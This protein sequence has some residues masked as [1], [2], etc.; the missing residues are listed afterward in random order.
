MK[1]RTIKVIA[2]YDMSDFPIDRITPKEYVEKM[3]K[4]DMV[5]QFGWDEGYLGVKVEVIDE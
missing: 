4:K 1:K 3:V 5:D 2:T